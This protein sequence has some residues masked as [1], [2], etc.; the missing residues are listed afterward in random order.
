MDHRRRWRR[1]TAPVRVR[2]LV[3]QSGSVR[4]RGL[5]L[6]LQGLEHAG[7]DGLHD[8]GPQHV[9]GER[10]EHGSVYRLHPH[11]D[12]VL[13]HGLAALLVRD[14]PVNEGACLPRIATQDAHAAATDV[15][16]CDTGQQVARLHLQRARKQGQRLSRRRPAHPPRRLA[17]GHRAVG[18]RGRESARRPGIARAPGAGTSVFKN[19]P[20]APLGSPPKR[21]HMAYRCR[22]FRISCFATAPEIL[23]VGHRRQAGHGR[24]QPIGWVPRWR[25]LKR[26][27]ILTTVAVV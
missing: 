26:S 18:A 12:A 10:P 5:R 1:P 27:R 9:V 22:C 20:A 23:C 24:G 19:L 15:A 13:A 25:T 2:P 4:L 14:A 21:R 17:A 3:V 16:A 6:R 7:D 11:N 8:G